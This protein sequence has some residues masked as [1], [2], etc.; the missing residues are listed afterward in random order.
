MSVYIVTWDLNREKPNYTQARANFIAR[1][2][3][4]TTTRDAGLDS[5]RFVSTDLSAQALY[6]DLK[7]RIDTNDRLLVTKMTPLQY[8][9]WLDGE[10]VNWLKTK[11]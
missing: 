9:G 6:A 5:V 8:A 11:I 2:N 1:L 10:V 7:Q 3:Q 4:Y